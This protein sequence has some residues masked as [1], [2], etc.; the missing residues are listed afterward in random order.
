[1][2]YYQRLKTSSSEDLSIGSMN[3]SVDSNV[4]SV[5]A[6]WEV[7]VCAAGKFAV[8]TAGKFAVVQLG[9]LLSVQLQVLDSC[10]LQ[11]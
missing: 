8:G 5:R 3:V 1:M 7:A 9:E 2:I 6:G 4:G 11:V 10:M